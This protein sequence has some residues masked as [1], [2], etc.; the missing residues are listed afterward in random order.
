MARCPVKR[1]SSASEGGREVLTRTTQH[2]RWLF[3]QQRA[4]LYSELAS[5]LQIKHNYRFS[6]LGV[7]GTETDEPNQICSPQSFPEQW[8]CD[9]AFPSL[10]IPYR[11]NTWN[12]GKACVC[13][14]KLIG[15]V[16]NNI[17]VTSLKHEEGHEFLQHPYPLSNVC[18]HWGLWLLSKNS[19]WIAV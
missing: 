2:R 7:L 14:L 3:V 10:T 18:S 1:K 17:S 12:E 5:P 6:L 13:E 4:S 16:F 15:T 8:S 9:M 11:L 19:L